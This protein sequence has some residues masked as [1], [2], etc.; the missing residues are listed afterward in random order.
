MK[1]SA[2]DKVIVTVV[3]L[4]VVLGL[5]IAFL[6]VPQF[7]KLSGID[8]EI[9]EAEADVQ[10]QET[11]L[12][13]RE[14]MKDQAAATDAKALKL[15]S[16]VPDRPDLAS[17]I[18]ELQDVAFSSG[19]KLTA[20]S[21]TDPV[22]ADA[23]YSTI[24]ID[25]TVQGTWTDSVDFLQKIPRLTRG[26]RTTGFSAGVLDN[27]DVPELSPYPVQTLVNIEAYFIPPASAQ[28]P[29]PET[30]TEEPAPAQ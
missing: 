13:Q 28:E 2:K 11:L 5:A 17:L 24:P 19:V 26:I 21:P 20:I 10:M 15:G 12:R 7:T 30:G 25:L 8:Q 14:A 18:I 27:E 1:I 4:L 29:A 3:A 23:I 9:K 22:G 6:I 16:L